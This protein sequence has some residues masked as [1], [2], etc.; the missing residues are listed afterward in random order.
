MVVACQRFVTAF[1]KK[2]DPFGVLPACEQWV[3]PQADISGLIPKFVPDADKKGWRL[4]TS[5]LLQVAKPF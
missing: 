3:R 4:E 2:S 1:F 5:Q